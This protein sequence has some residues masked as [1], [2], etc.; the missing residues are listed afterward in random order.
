MWLGMCKQFLVEDYIFRK[1]KPGSLSLRFSE[2]S[3]VYAE[4]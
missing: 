2:D 4:Q 3:V 1:W